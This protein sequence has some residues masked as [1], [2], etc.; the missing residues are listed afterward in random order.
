[1]IVYLSH[2]YTGD[3]EKNIKHASSIALK[4]SER[5]TV[6]S[7]LN[8]FD[9]INGEFTYDR[10]MKM[11]LDLLSKADKLVYYG[12]SKGVRIEIE[13]AKKWGIPVEEWKD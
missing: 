2:P 4:L 13:W 8:N 6:F 7:P 1:M 5:Y 12:D 10:M 3:T 11:C 9:F